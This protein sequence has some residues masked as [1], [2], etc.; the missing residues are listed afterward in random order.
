MECRWE[1]RRR[2]WGVTTPRRP[3]IGSAA[4]QTRRQNRM[5]RTRM[6]RVR[7][8]VRAAS[9]TPRTLGARR[10]RTS[11]GSSS[12]IRWRRR[13][14]TPP[15]ARRPSRAMLRLLLRSRQAGRG[16]RTRSTST[17]SRSGSGSSK[18]SSRLDLSEPRRHRPACR[19][20]GTPTRAR[21]APRPCRGG[22]RR[23]REATRQHPRPRDRPCCSSL[24][25]T[26]MA[27]TAVGPRAHPHAV[28]GRTR[29]RSRRPAPCTAAAATCHDPAPPRATGTAR[30]APLAWRTPA[31]GPG[32]SHSVT[33]SPAAGAAQK[34]PLAWR[35]LGQR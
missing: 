25:G 4:R 15:S 28:P 33:T 14:T 2:C 24:P 30:G 17:E 31:R 34:A 16:M 18:R 11:R 7:G 1:A 19:R 12:A 20:T 35:L 21:M 10:S 6:P 27:C 3:R 8:S 26:T 9:D 13:P 29:R 22:G 5:S 32:S 23:P